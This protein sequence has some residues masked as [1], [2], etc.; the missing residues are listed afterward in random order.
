MITAATVLLEEAGI[1]NPRWVAEQLLAR[2]AGRTPLELLLEPL[3]PTEE[4]RIRFLADVAA[5]AGG[6]PMQYVM[7][8]AQ[9]YGR[10]FEVGPGVFIPRPETE[11]LIETALEF[12]PPA[13]R[14]ADICTGSGAIAVTLMRERPDLQLFATD[15]SETALGFARRNA[16]RHGAEITFFQADL[17]GPLPPGSI[18]LLVANLPYLDPQ[19]ASLWP[20]ELHWEP[21]LAQ[22]GG[23]RG[24]ALLRRLIQEGV[25]RLAPRGQMILEIG[26]GQAAEISDFGRSVQ[27]KTERVILDLTGRE[28]VMLLQKAL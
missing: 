12:I 10:E 11:M 28:R 4:Q 27:L 16:Q 18:D 5:C 6:M 24:T 9:F 15:R 25:S 13:R 17:V 19:Q 22:D 8:S 23:E 14:I 1:V 26:D 3:V 2:R 7:G 20:R 21:W